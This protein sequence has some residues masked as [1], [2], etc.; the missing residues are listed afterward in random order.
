MFSIRRAHVVAALFVV[1]LAPL[2]GLARCAGTVH[3]TPAAVV[4]RA[5]AKRRAT[6]AERGANRPTADDLLAAIR[7]PAERR[8]PA[9]R[10]A[11]PDQPPAAT[12]R[13]ADRPAA[14]DR[15]AANQL[16]AEQCAQPGGLA[17]AEHLADR[18]ATDHDLAERVADAERPTDGLSAAN[19]LPGTK[20]SGGAVDV[21]APS[22]TDEDVP[23]VVLAATE[24][25]VQQ[26]SGRKGRAV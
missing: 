21:S 23:Q 14:D 6:A 11:E 18:A 1:A 24:R 5:A 25:S 22:L 3:G 4:R 20:Q 9:G 13:L 8:A 10:Y 17:A 15:S 19:A 16:S 2:F 7:Q 26:V 12:D